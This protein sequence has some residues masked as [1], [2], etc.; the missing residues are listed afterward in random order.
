MQRDDARQDQ[1][2]DRIEAHGSQR[3]DFLA[4]LHGAEL[5]GEG[6]A[7][8]ARHH[9]GD[10]QDADFAQHQDAD[11]VDDIDVGAEFAEVED[12]LLRDDAAD[13]ERDQQDD[14]HRAPAD[15]VELV[16]HRGEAE[17]ARMSS[18]ARQRGHDRAQHADE[19]GKRLPDGR[20]AAPDRGNHVHQRTA[21]AMRQRLFRLDAVNLLHQRAIVV[22]EPGHLGGAAARGEVAGQPLQQPGAEGVELIDRGHVDIDALHGAAAP[23]RG[24]DLGFEGAGVLGD[25]RA[26]AG[27][28]ELLAFGGAFQQC[29]AH[30]E[31][32]FSG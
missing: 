29:N 1:H 31:Q 25:P 6:A 22:L 21:A 26:G 12:A 20:D 24:V 14:R 3:V 13:Q 17:P 23:G 30:F 2:F 11:H 28:L 8:A 16:H 18:D 4:H 5:G 10:D 7:G 9:D 19:G 32:A 15:I 27:K